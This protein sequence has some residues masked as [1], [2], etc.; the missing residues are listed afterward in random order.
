ML[1]IGLIACL[2][3]WA[4]SDDWLR[5]TRSASG[6]PLALEVAIGRFERAD[7]ARVDL[8]GAVHVGEPAYYQD[9]NQRFN[10]YQR[11]LFELVGRPEALESPAAGSPSLIG[12]L[13]G[14]MKN[15]LGLAFQLDEIDYSAPHFVHADLDADEFAA[16]M[17]AR[18]ESWLQLAVRAWA[19]GLAEQG[20]GEAA[21]SN[22]ALLKVLLAEDRERAL[23]RALAEELADQ[24]DSLTRLAGADGST[25][26]EVRNGR[27]LEVLARELAAGHQRVAIF[28]GAGH[29]PDLARRLEQDLGFRR[30]R[31]E[32]ISA[33]DLTR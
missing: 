33:W 23:K 10:D 3:A 8:V 1:C 27:A 12:L 14:G 24:G 5:V 7:G 6:E 18:N 21:R 16:S 29:M 4:E 9:L 31:L 28:Y 30:A 2:P 19:L 13:Q 22:A 20:S 25:L 15:A 17:R 11:V 32:W 26:I